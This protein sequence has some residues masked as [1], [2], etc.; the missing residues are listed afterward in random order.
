M[1]GQEIGERIQDAGKQATDDFKQAVREFSPWVVRLGRLGFAAIGAVYI[2]VGVLALQAAISLREAKTGTRGALAYIAQLPLGQILL[3]LVAA[4]FVF[5]ALWRFTQ[6]L[7]DTDRKGSDKR[8]KTTRLGFAGV[9]LV[10]LGLA[11]SAVKII[12]G[13]RSDGGFWARS[14][15]AW[16]LEQPFGAW[17]VALVGA[18]IF[19]AGI[20]FFYQS[21]SAKFR[22]TLL[23]AEMSE[24]WE[25]WGVRFGRFGFAARG[26]IFCI[27]GVFFGFAAWFSDAG[28]S[29]DFAGALRFVERQSYGA[30]LL[31]LIAAGLFSYGIFMFFLAKCRRMVC[32]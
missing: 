4:G 17:L 28:E 16:L 20:Y 31:A 5:H 13:A 24:R 7:M 19:L 14:W 3:A 30:W 1:N 29:R 6:A 11:F 32:N 26:V 23:F 12:L 15:T 10:Y 21:L 27:I 9:G 18:G 2:L 8:G 22:E 25:K